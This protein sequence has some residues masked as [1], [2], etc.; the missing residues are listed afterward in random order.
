MDFNHNELCSIESDADRA[1]RAL[2][3]FTDGSV[4]RN[5]D[6]ALYILAEVRNA[7][8]ILCSTD[9]DSETRHQVVERLCQ[10][11]RED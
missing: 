6:A 5:L 10:L 3:Q 1:I 2:R 7:S 9:T 4:K 8:Q 11:F